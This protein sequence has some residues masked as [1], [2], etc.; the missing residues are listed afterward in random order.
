[1]N[2]W[3]LEYPKL[4]RDIIKVLLSFLRFIAIIT[5]LIT[6]I[7]V[8][9][10]IN[11][12]VI[13]IIDILLVLL[14]VFTIK[15]ENLIVARIEIIDS[16]IYKLDKSNRKTIIGDINDIT[17]YKQ[18]IISI[19]VLKNSKT[20]FSFKIFPFNDSKAFYKYLTSNIRKE[21]H[22][23]NFTIKS[24]K[25][26]NY[27]SQIF[28]IIDCLFFVS[29]MILG[30]I[31]KSIYS[32]LGVVIS[33]ILFI[34]LFL[35]LLFDCIH[36]IIYTLFKLRPCYFEFEN[37]C[38]NFSVLK[39]FN[40]KKKKFNPTYSASGPYS[41]YSKGYKGILVKE[42]VTLRYENIKMIDYLIN[43][44]ISIPNSYLTHASIRYT[45]GLDFVIITND[46]NYFILSDLFSKKEMDRIYLELKSRIK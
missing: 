23:S 38:V 35:Y 15:I 1:M 3:N 41:R 36:Y 21:H 29:I 26:Y 14:W 12:V 24:Y 4:E 13:I 7:I 30:L 22:S 8:F 9:S 40:S 42:N 20:L 28:L 11:I 18:N 5:F 45:K 43:L 46:K 31:F 27:F 32:N 10:K 37:D 25:R 2:S 44:D 33:I 6:N 19:S 39:V 17:S 34:I 16:I